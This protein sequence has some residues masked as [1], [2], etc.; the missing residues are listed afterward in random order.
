M[1]GTSAAQPLGMIELRA[2]KGKQ[3]MAT[4]ASLHRGQQRCD[5]QQESTCLRD[6]RP[7][8]HDHVVGVPQ[9]AHSVF[10][11]RR[12]TST[13]LTRKPR[14]RTKE[15]QPAPSQTQRLPA[16]PPHFLSG[17]SQP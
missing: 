10:N 12:F 8:C 3:T 14:M 15:S 9:P 13:I 7:R 4:R 1:I 17:L 5:G 2:R 6:W 16:E 11:D